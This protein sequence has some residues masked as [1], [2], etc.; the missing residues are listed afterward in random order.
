MFWTDLSHNQL[1]SLTSSQFSSLAGLRELFLTHNRLASL[2]SA[3]FTPLTS[4]HRLD[5]QSNQ[6]ED[7][8]G[9]LAGLPALRHLNLANNRLKWFDMAFFPKT[10][11]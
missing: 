3:V 7:V 1:S 5:L 8:N 4:L 10:V 2:A 9:L 6:L 11:R